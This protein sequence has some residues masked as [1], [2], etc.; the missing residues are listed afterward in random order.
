MSRN[1][2]TNSSENL[3]ICNETDR[4]TSGNKVVNRRLELTTSQAEIL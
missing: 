3:L 1:P 4:V 2:R